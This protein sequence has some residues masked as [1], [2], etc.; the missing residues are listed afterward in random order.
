MAKALFV[1]TTVAVMRRINTL[2]KGAGAQSPQKP[3]HR[4]VPKS[5]FLPPHTEVSDIADYNVKIQK[6]II[7]TI[8]NIQLMITIYYIVIIDYM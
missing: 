2:L 3:H 8:Y 5:D 1:R 6:Y 4:S 7:C